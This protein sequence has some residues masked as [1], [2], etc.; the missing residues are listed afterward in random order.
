VDAGNDVIFVPRVMVKILKNSDKIMQNQKNSI[1]KDKKVIDWLAHHDPNRDDFNDHVFYI[2]NYAVCIGCFAFLLGATIA[3]IIG[4]IFYYYI[5]NFISLSIILMFFFIGWIPSIFQYGI[6]ILR[7]KP[8]KN[9]IVKFTCRFLY[10][11]GSIIF[12][13]KSPIW[14]LAI[15]IPAGYVI[16]FIRKIKNKTLKT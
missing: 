13:F 7:K 16:I 5:V 14:G 1:Q 8:L 3:L 4:N 6:Q 15:S 11:V 2:F 12:I 10:P 9:R